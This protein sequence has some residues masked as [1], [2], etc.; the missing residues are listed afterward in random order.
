MPW[1]LFFARRAER[2]L[3]TLDE[4]VRAAIMG[5]IRAAAIDPSSVDLTKLRGWP[6][7]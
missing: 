2:D 3:E 4:A 7:E 5:R 6:G 1:T